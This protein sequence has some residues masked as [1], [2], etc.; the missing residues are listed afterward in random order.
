MP[1]LSGLHI[2]PTTSLAFVVGTTQS[3]QIKVTISLV[4][5]HS[6]LRENGM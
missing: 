4:A 6:T 2:A 1:Y 5:G 3:L